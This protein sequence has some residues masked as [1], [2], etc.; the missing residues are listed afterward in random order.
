[1]NRERYDYV[2][3]QTEQGREK[4]VRHPASGEEGRVL[5]C[6]NDDLEV[7]NTA[8]EKRTWNYQDVEEVT[9]SKE[10]FPRPN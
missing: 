3:V 5:S 8:G 6:S 7:E 4:I 10:E 2:R 1:M 9:R